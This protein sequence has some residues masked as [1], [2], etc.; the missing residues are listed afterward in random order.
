VR[1]YTSRAHESW[2]ARALRPAGAAHQLSMVAY[3][4]SLAGGSVL[5]FAGFVRCALVWYRAHPSRNFSHAALNDV[6][7]NGAVTPCSRS[8]CSVAR[9][10][11]LAGTNAEAAICLLRAC[12][13]RPLNRKC[14]KR[15]QA[16]NSI[17]AA[18]YF[19][20]RYERR[21]ALRHQT[22]AT[23]RGSSQNRHQS[24]SALSS[25]REIK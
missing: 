25:S 2:S 22:P 21:P 9:V 17:L 18:S 11:P 6:A 12:E 8:T 13:R 15:R 7:I 14:G 3:E 24:E 19:V 4:T 20:L 10:S 1:I 23:N 5:F 16:K